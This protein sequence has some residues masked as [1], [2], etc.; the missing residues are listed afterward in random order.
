[1]IRKTD[2]NVTDASKDNTIMLVD[3]AVTKQ[4]LNKKEYGKFKVF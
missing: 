3:E 2:F 4:N 1:M